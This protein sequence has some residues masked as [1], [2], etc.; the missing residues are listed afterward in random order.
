MSYEPSPISRA[1]ELG[2]NAEVEAKLDRL[3]AASETERKQRNIAITVGVLSALF[4][5][6]RLGILAVPLVKKARGR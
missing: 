5:A 2:D 3:L 4:A 1:Y 6:G